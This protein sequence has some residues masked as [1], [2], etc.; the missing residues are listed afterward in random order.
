[1][2]FGY[3]AEFEQTR[4]T[5]LNV[6]RMYHDYLEQVCFAEQHRF[7]SVWVLEH[8]LTE[9]YSYCSAPEILLTAIA[10]RTSTIRLG[11]GVCLL[12]YH[13]PVTVAERYATLD[14]LSGGRLEFG[15]GRGVASFEWSKFRDEPYDQS[16]DMMYEALELVLKCWTQDNVVHDGRYYKVTQ[17]IN[18]IPKPIQKPHPR[19]HI[20]GTSPESA[21]LYGSLG[22]NVLG[23]CNFHPNVEI[24]RQAQAFREGLSCSKGPQDAEF[25]VILFVHCGKSDREADARIGPYHKWFYSTMGKSYG[26][27]QDPNPAN[28]AARYVRNEAQ[29]EEFKGRGM[30]VSGS[31]ETC[32]KALKGMESAGVD[33]VMCQFR[34]GLM[35][36]Q[37]IMESL[38]L[39]CKEV[40]PA[41]QEQSGSRSLTLATAGG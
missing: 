16:R 20:A 30:I 34:L 19:V 35:P 38:A 10:A 29:F 23:I 5:S 14:I 2:K 7:E 21:G 27:D 13:N 28:L 18:V 41:F 17:P 26:I 11:P 9:T 25:S 36:H 4:E 33:R 6:P 31:P 22:W 1:M 37:E 12:P 39:F 24:K 8:H 32:I 15:V 40:V 3:F